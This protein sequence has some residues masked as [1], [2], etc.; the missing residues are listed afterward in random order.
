MAGWRVHRVLQEVGIGAAEHAG[1]Q[2]TVGVGQDGA[3]ADDAGRRVHRV[4]REVQTAGVLVGAFVLQAHIDHGAL[5]GAALAQIFQQDRLGPVE[6]EVDRAARD[7]G[8]QH[9]AGRRSAGDDV[10][11]I[12]A[13]VRH[14]TRGRRRDAGVVQVQAAYYMD[15]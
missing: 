13:P 6:D 12:D 15:R 4:V 3:Q 2:E 9:V 11:G 10:A 5:V 14:P 8:G 1:A 7:D